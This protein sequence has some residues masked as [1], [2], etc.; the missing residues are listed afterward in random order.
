MSGI[1]DNKL[2]ILDTILTFEGRRQIALGNL[3]IVSA[4]FSDATAFYS[5]DVANGSSDATVRIYLE[6][7]ELPQDQITFE[8]D[9]SGKLK[10]FGTESD[11][12]LSAGQLIN[13][14]FSPTTSSTIIEGSNTTISTLSGSI[15]AS[16]ITGILSSSLDNFNKL[17]TIGTRDVAFEESSGFA[18]GPSDIEFMIHN[19]S[20]IYDPNDWVM[21]VNHLENLFNDPRLSRLNNFNYLPPV[22]KVVDE[23]IDT[24][25]HRQLS[26]YMLGEYLPWG[27]S[28]MFDLT[29]DA[30]KKELST[31]EKKGYMKSITFDP[32]SNENKMI[33][34]FFEISSKSVSKLDIIDFGKFY[35]SKLSHAISH[36]FFVGKVITNDSGVQSFIHI[37]TLVFE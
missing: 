34:Q 18:C 25:D 12:A 28:H 32:T 20:P 19:K 36:I 26:K 8:A 15:F 24:K 6:S 23:S 37:F 33:G 17:Y 29:Y 9:D 31:Y 13:Y 2:R 30:I 16:E 11:Y 35:N 1:L 21:N 5:G 27:R 7:C 4:S 14:S 22:N 3:K 10:P